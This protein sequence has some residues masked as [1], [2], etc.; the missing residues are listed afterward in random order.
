MMIQRILALAAG[1]LVVAT[2]GGW[3]QEQRPTAPGQPQAARALRAV[4]TGEPAAASLLPVDFR[5]VMGY[6]PADGATGPTKAGG[7]CSSPFGGTG[8]HFSPACRQHDLGY[9]LLRYAAV[10]GQPLGSWARKAVDDRFARQTR[11][12][13]HEFGCWAMADL[14]TGFVRFNSWRQGYGT[15]V[16]E[17]ISTLALPVAG[18][19]IT[20]LLFGVLPP[21]RRRGQL[22][23]GTPPEAARFIGRP[24]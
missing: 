22:V 9:D 4:T 14:Y 17:P 23:V 5:T 16:A 12:R 21:P 7:G 1:F 6:W 2:I 19:L 20:A 3:G 8:Y 13:C 24:A 18:G 10:K 15:P 11:A